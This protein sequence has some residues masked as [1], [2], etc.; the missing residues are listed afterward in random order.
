MSNPFYY[1]SIFLKGIDFTAKPLFAKPNMQNL[2][3]I[4]TACIIF[5]LEFIQHCF[6]GMVVLRIVI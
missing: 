6:Y 5:Q 4:L 2:L 1:R 3:D